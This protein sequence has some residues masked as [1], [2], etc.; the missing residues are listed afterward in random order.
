MDW[1]LLN[2]T[3]AIAHQVFPRDKVSKQPVPP[4]CSAHAFTLSATVTDVL[5]KRV[6]AA[7]SQ[8]AHGFEMGIQKHGSDSFCNV[9]GDIATGNVAAFV[10]L[11]QQLAT[12][13]NIAQSVRNLP[14]GALIIMRCTIGAAALPCCILIKAELQDGFTMEYAN[15]DFAVRL[16][17]ELLLTESQRLYKMGILVQ[18]TA[19]PKRTDGTHAPAG[20]KA[21]VFD[22]QMSS[23]ETREAAHYF[24]V[25]FLG[26]SRL[27]SAR[28]STQN[29][30]EATREFIKNSAM[31]D[32]QK[33]SAYD[34]LR[35]YLKSN[36]ATINPT[37]FANNHFP[38]PEVRDLY[39]Q[40]LDEMGVGT[41]TIDKDI[42]N[43]K[44]KL[45][46]PKMTFSSGVSIVAP[47]ER[48]GDF[49]TIL[50][51]VEGQDANHTRLEIRG[52]IDGQS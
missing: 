7:I 27:P 13:L 47:G 42:A 15:G 49:V 29:Y 35:V 3:N 40:Y 4:K 6:T 50:P 21:F 32:D 16:L 34:A 48:V 37:T 46:R 8:N 43:I 30:Y 33:I 17:E 45:S 51:R 11:S 41:A 12:S 22:Y 28:Q 19:F 44:S 18:E 52:L 2:I 14:G 5:R 23:K 38:T 25:E 31:N 20:F 24:S 39:A 9:G 1:S 10:T 36:A 26:L